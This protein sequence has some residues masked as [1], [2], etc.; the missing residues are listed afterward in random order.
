MAAVYVRNVVLNL[1]I[2]VSGFGALLLLPRLIDGFWRGPHDCIP[3]G[4]W[5]LFAGLVLLGIAVVIIAIHLK[6]A[7]DMTASSKPARSKG[8]FGPL[9]VQ[10]LC[11][12]PLIVSSYLMA[13][14]AW[15][16]IGREDIYDTDLTAGIFW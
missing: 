4:N 10:A 1:A 6:R 12:V 9:W 14:W 3:H 13:W 5:A 8:F 2:L 7:N 16:N 11:V 15:I